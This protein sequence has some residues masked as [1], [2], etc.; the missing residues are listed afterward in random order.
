[1]AVR[2]LHTEKNARF[3]VG[4]ARISVSHEFFLLSYRESNPQNSSDQI[5]LRLFQSF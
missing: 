5:Y 1:M 3:P 2:P 4:Y